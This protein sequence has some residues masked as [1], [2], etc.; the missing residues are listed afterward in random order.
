MGRRGLLV[1]AGIGGLTAAIALR[2][3]GIET[4][5]FEQGAELRRVQIGG[6]L[7][8]WNNG[9]R[10]LQEAGVAEPVEAIGTTLDELDFRSWR[11]G[12]LAKWPIDDITR[13]VGAPAVG[14]IRGDLHR[15]LTEA[16]EDGVLRVGA[17]VVG[18]EQHAHGVTV[19]LAD[20]SEEQG[21]F[22]VVA[23]GRY[24][25]LRERVVGPDALRDPGVTVQFSIID[26]EHELTPP[27]TVRNWWGPGIRFSCFR[28][29]PE[30]RLYWFTI[31]RK[32][33]GG[34]PPAE[35][36][37]Q[38]LLERLRGWPEPIPALVAATGEPAVFALE[39]L[40]RK[41]VKRWSDGRITLLG[42]AAHP[43]TP[44]HRARHV[45]G[46][47]GRGR[48]GAMPRSRDGRSDC[49]PRLRASA[50]AAR[51][52]TGQGIRANRRDHSLGAAASVCTAGSADEDRGRG[53]TLEAG[54]EGRDV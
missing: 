21:D 28:V 34:A 13:K 15:T 11:R 20:G 18:L 35:E 23:D 46:A 39:P 3:A 44:G 29:G 27:G 32:Q 1:G 14:V 9:M 53:P 26:F 7:M 25:E 6:G 4:T 31:G 42:D 50:R 37:R 24:S 43:M 48:P 54:G 49:V 22:A 5:I 10:A 16:L 19:R 30:Q 47:R 51:C 38:A 2:R 52:R 12:V 17:P 41:P 45:P 36:R 33:S 40:Y 8:L